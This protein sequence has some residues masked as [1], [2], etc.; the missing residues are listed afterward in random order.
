MAVEK[1]DLNSKKLDEIQIVR[2]SAHEMS[3][4]FNISAEGDV[5]AMSSNKKGVWI[6]KY[7][8]QLFEGKKK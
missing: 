3:T 7:P 4:P 8:A 5:Y 6:D 1:F 2:Q